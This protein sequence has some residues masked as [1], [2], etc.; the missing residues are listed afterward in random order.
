MYVQANDNE[1]IY[2]IK[3]GNQ[4]AYRTLYIKYEHL[5]RKIYNENLKTRGICFADFL[6][7][8]MMCLNRAIYTFKETFGCTFYSYFLVIIRKNYSKLMRTNALYLKE[9]NTEYTPENLFADS[10]SKSFLVDL[11]IRE[12][13]LTD[14]LEKDLFYECIL[15]N[16][17]VVQIAKKYKKKYTSVYI[18]YKKIKEK[19]EKILTNAKV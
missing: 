1:L 10:N 18:K 17:K 2:L 14:D 12:L 11:V 5:I 13:E 3:E 15:K 7:E 19:I 9:H 16:V 6:Q 8:C 4:A